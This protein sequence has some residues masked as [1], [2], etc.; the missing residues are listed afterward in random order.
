ME[1]NGQDPKK[2]P[3]RV[4]GSYNALCRG[5]NSESDAN[6]FS[7]AASANTQQQNTIDRQM[8]INSD[9]GFGSGVQK[10]KQG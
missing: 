7:K 8:D 4:S 10:K 1:A 3:A 5:W 2:V 6:L 9:D